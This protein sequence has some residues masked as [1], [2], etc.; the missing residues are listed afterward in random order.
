[1]AAI[2]G[3][4]AGAAGVPARGG[5]GNV[6]PGAPVPHPNQQAFQ[7]VLSWI[8]FNADTRQAIINEA[9]NTLSDLFDIAEV[10]IGKLVKHVGHWWSTNLPNISFP[11]LCV[12]KLKALRWWA[13]LRVHQG[14]PA[15]PDDFSVTVCKTSLKY[16]QEEREIKDAL[17]N[18]VPQKPPKLGWDLSK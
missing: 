8:G 7:A 9:F 17:E 18:Q 13:S 4:G 15:N 3:V 14:M 11:F 16:L 1:M 10:Q 5:A 6:N 2:G 12:Q